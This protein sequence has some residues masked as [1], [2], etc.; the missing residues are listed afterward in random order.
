MRDLNTTSAKNGSVYIAYFSEGNRENAFR[1]AGGGKGGSWLSADLR[2]NAFKDDLF[3]SCYRPAFILSQ[4][5]DV[6]PSAAVDRMANRA[7]ANERTRRTEER[8][9][10]WPTFPMFKCR[11]PPSY[12][13]S[14]MCT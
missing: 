9:S 2:I 7:F 4:L 8:L 14:S 12:S 11:W 5:L 3:A 1:H 6:S 13:C 10:L